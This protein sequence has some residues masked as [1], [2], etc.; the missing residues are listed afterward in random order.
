M[1][2]TTMTTIPE[3]DPAFWSALDAALTLDDG[4]AALTHL[5]AG[6]P[7]YCCAQ[8]TPEG[9]IGKHYPDGHR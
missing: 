1:R 4:A 6:N 7:V 5:A 9:V 3:N 8:D 2:A